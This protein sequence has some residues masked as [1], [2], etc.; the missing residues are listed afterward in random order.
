MD[1]LLDMNTW[2]T[3]ATI[4]LAI[5]VGLAVLAAVLWLCWTAFSI[6]FTFA[7]QVAVV[8]I[9][10]YILAWLVGAPIL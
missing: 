4:L 9:L 10:L 3:V 2:Q 6:I 5:P 8:L 7:F 1:F